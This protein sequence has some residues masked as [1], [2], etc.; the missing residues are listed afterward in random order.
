MVNV[1]SGQYDAWLRAVPLARD[2][3][4]L[5]ASVESEEHVEQVLQRR[6]QKLEIDFHRISRDTPMKELERCVSR[7]FLASNVKCVG[8]LGTAS[9]ALDVLLGRS[10]N[11]LSEGNL[12]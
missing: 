11:P 9:T 4:P 5:R 8:H 10:T 3:V 7:G 2:C 1:S 6:R 12:R